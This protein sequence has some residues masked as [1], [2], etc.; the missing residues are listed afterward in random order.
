MIEISW[1]EITGSHK[2]ASIISLDNDR[3]REN[4][5]WGILMHRVHNQYE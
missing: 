3:K 1:D 5:P 2:V 4:I